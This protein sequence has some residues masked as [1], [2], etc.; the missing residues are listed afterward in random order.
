MPKQ[1]LGTMYNTLGIEYYRG[2]GVTQDKETAAQWYT[3]A[4]EQED[5]DAASGGV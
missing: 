1:E 2:L 3:L 4:S 5:R